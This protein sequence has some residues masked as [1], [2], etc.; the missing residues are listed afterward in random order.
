LE[1]IVDVGMIVAA[2]VEVIE[3]VSV[4]VIEAGVSYILIRL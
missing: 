2:S 4:G 1:V 3:E